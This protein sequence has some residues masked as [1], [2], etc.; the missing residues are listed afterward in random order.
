MI[1]NLQPRSQAISL[2]L[3]GR[4][5]IALGSAVHVISKYPAFVGILNLHKLTS[6]M[7]NNF[8]MAAL[9]GVFLN[10]T[11]RDCIE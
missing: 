3:G 7:L 2:G 5:E 11:N 1:T 6:N 9:L 8:K 10:V 4:R